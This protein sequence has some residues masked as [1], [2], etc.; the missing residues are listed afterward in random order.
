MAY[1]ITV[2]CQGCQACVRNCPTQAITG[3]RHEVHV[4]DPRRC[5]DCGTCGRVC[6]YAAVLDPDGSLAARVRR[7]DWVIPIVDRKS[8][9]SCG[10]CV[11]ICPVS[12]LDMDFTQRKLPQEGIPVLREP[13]ACVGCGFCEAICPVG[14]ITLAPRSEI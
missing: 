14:A 3:I 7:S 11:T 4:I 2:D 5:I 12:C 1:Q 9:V 8:C 13:N 6:P 10:L